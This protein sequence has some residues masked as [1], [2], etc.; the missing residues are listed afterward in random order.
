MALDINNIALSRCTVSSITVSTAGAHD[1]I[2]SITVF[3]QR[4]S[5]NTSYVD[6]IDPTIGTCDAYRAQRK[7]SMD[8]I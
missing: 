2:V 5:A 1:L 8:L 4:V 7:L 6:S 3:G